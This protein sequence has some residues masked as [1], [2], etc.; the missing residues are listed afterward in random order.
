MI[1]SIFAEKIYWNSM[2]I[3]EL[4]RKYAQQNKKRKVFPP[5]DKGHL[6]KN[7][8][9]IAFLMVNS[10]SLKSEA[11]QMSALSSSKSHC[12]RF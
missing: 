12:T 5:S 7:T 11:R 4:K 8:Q 1:I 9:L 2:C 10:S 6:H 3:P